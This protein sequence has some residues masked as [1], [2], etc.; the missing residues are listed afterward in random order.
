[1]MERPR[2]LRPRR[3]LLCLLLLLPGGCQKERRTFV[4]LASEKRPPS[5]TVAS[6]RTGAV[7]VAPSTRLV[8]SI[9]DP[10]AAVEIVV[11]A[12]SSPEERWRFAPP[13]ADALLVQAIPL[14]RGGNEIEL[15][16]KNR[17]GVTRARLE[18]ERPVPSSGRALEVVLSWEVA[19]EGTA[20]DLDLH[21]VR[22]EGTLGGEEDCHYAN[23]LGTLGLT[24]DWGGRGVGEDDPRLTRDASVGT[25]SPPSEAIL[26]SELEAGMSYRVVVTPFHGRASAT[27][28]VTTPHAVD[29]FGPEIL[30]A[31]DPSLQAWEVAEILP[32]SATVIEGGG[33]STG[34]SLRQAPG[35]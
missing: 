11:Q 33:V 1:M 20:A 12:T 28:T 14:F 30:D 4:G 24:L 2:A 5:I 21:L 13:L 7:V 34:D 26:L 16:A 32:P 27:V 23:C 35:E 29:R 22:G 6:P 18:V 8:A 25:P 15:S 17:F 10:E 31:D 3:L 9:D 19:G